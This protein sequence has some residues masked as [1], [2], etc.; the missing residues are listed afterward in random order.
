VTEKSFQFLG[1]YDPLKGQMVQILNPDGGCDDRLRPDLQEEELRLLYRH[2]VLARLMD[3]KALS[4]Q[5]QGRFVTFAQLEGQEAAQVGSAS[6]LK[7]Q[8]WIIPSYREFGAMLVHGVPLSLLCTYLVGS[9]EGH[10]MPQDVRC[11]PMAIP[12]GSQPLHAMGIAWAAKLKREPSVAIAYFGDGA[13]SQGDVH[14]AMNF[15]A[16]YQVPCIFFCQNN[17]YAISVH[18][19]QQAAAPTLAQRGIAYGMPG[20]Q[21]DGN[22]IFAAYAVTKEAVDR[23]RAG[24]GPCFI[25]AVTYRIGAHTTA[26]DP[27]RYR[28]AGEVEEWRKRDPI[29]RFRR[30]LEARKLWNEDREQK[31]REGVSAEIDAAI[32][33][34]EK[35]PP[36]KAEDVFR[37]MFAEMT[38]QL[39]E[40]QAM[41]K[42]ALRSEKR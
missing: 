3:R 23:A 16:V 36:S 25:E 42:A 21:I 10:R 13:S 27:T 9:E 12:V 14:E 7:P 39:R 34:A 24:G 40:Q 8:D 38:P 37:Y 31:L 5:R 35:L 17:H 22:D 18:R 20:V 19:S 26:D 6:A 29:D 30:Y 33:V 32:E 28:E 1:K 4:L 41:L 11:L 15:A 2:M